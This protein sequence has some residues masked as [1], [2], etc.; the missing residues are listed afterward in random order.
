[1]GEKEDDRLEEEK[2]DVEGRWGREEERERDW[3]GMDEVSLFFKI[4]M[5]SELF[6][7]SFLPCLFVVACSS[8]CVSLCWSSL[9]VFESNI[10]EAVIL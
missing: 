10:K 2:G 9:S 1:M 4:E 8:C 6:C 5:F 3:V 7:L